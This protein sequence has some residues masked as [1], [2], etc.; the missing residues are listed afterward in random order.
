MHLAPLSTT[1]LYYRVYHPSSSQSVEA[2]HDA[3]IMF[4]GYHTSYLISSAFCD[5]LVYVLLDS[6]HEIY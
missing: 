3:I 2:K 1:F 4:V 5:A 6:F